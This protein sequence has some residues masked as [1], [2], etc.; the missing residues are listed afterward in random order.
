MSIFPAA[1]AADGEG[2]GVVPQGQ[3]DLQSTEIEERRDART[4]LTTGSGCA[5]GE[6]LAA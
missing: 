3:Y 5:A 2:V 4:A 6:C 1:A